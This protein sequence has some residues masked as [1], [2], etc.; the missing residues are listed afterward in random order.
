WGTTDLY[1]NNWRY[2][3]KV[4]SYSLLL[5]ISWV[6]ISNLDAIMIERMLDLKQA[7]IYGRTMFFGV[8]VAIPYR[9]IHKISSGLLSGSFKEN[10]MDNVRDIYYKSTMSQLVLAAFIFTGIWLNIHNV[11]HVIPESYEA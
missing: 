6:G 4:A 1:R 5:G 8:L 2:M 7:G 3:T 9:A 10:N 11:F